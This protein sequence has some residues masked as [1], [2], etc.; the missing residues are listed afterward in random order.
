MKTYECVKLVPTCTDDAPFFDGEKCI[1]CY[2]PKYWNLDD[3]QCVECP[4]NRH[5]DVGKKQCISCPQDY[6]FDLAS[7]TCIKVEVF[8][9]TPTC[10]DDRPFYNGEKCVTCY[11]P[12]YWDY[13]DN[14]C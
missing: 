5:Y 10:P 1:T 9:S 14:K 3:K 13:T 6:K 8:P 12:R 4:L 11:L 7:Y 2:L